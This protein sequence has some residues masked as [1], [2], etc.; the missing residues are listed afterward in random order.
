MM[1]CASGEGGGTKVPGGGNKEREEEEAR[2]EVLRRTSHIISE[3]VGDTHI[4][5]RSGGAKTRL[6]TKKKCCLAKKKEI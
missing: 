4:C 5:K 3:N 1:E 2:K 6:S